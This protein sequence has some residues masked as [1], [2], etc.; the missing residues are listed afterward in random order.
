MTMN[1]PDPAEDGVRQ[2]SRDSSEESVNLDGRDFVL[3]EG[4]KA[5]SQGSAGKKAKKKK[6]RRS[7]LAR[8]LIKIGI[9]GA[10]TAVT[11]IWVM[12]IY[13]QHGNSMYP[14]VMDGDLLIIFKAGSRYN[15]GDVILYR[16]PDTDEKGISR[17]VAIGSN[18]IQI[19][20]AGELLINGYV[21]S[22]TVFYRT[23]Q[24]QGSDV[25]FPYTM[26]EDEYF[27]LDDYRISGKDSRVFGAIKKDDLL[28]KVAYIL[29]R[30]GF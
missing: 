14:F 16:N 24:V 15:V 8:F 17:V 7:E 26:G 20:E 5:V 13:I 1:D 4:S 19:T 22:E 25:R 6:R 3:D 29:R 28:G 21:P 2:D 10:V 18:E 11:F 9:L 30:R 27:L 23:E 12:G